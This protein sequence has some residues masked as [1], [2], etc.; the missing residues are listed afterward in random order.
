M[1]FPISDIGWWRKH[2]TSFD[3]LCEVCRNTFRDTTKEAKLHEGS[4]F[5]LRLC[6]SSF[7]H[8]HTTL[9]K[10]GGGYV[11][12]STTHV[13]HLSSHPYGQDEMSITDFPV[14]FKRG[15]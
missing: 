13:G 7:L 8:F 9:P 1:P 12:S 2:N 5:S 3:A 11:C 6:V 14:G 15:F 10:R 4:A